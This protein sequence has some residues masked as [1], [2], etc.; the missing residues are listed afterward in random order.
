VK[1]EGGN[2][3]CP[4]EFRKAFK[5]FGEGGW[6]GLSRNTTYG[7][8][9]FPRKRITDEGRGNPFYA[10]KIM[11]AS[12]F[13]GTMLPLTMARLDTCI[14]PGREIIEMPNEAF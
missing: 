8:Q 12:Y 13:V 7:G 1:F 14:N 2:V 9:G 10:G 3:S 11:Q 5:Q 4:P 6:I